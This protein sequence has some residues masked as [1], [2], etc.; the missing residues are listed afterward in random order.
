MNRMQESSLL[1]SMQAKQ[2]DWTV[3]TKVRSKKTIRLVAMAVKSHRIRKANIKENIYKRAHDNKY[4]R[5]DRVYEGGFKEGSYHEHGRLVWSNGDSYE[6]SW[7]RGRMDGPGI[8]R[9]QSGLVLKGSFKA[10]YFIDE[11]VLR[12]PQMSEKEYQLFRKQRKEVIKQRERNE[13]VKHGFVVKAA[14]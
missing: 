9:Q 11:N 3:R 12:N 10:N 14:P 7:R 8:F 6:G 13:K 1:E 5:R 4:K 2:D